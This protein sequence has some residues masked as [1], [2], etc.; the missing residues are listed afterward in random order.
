MQLGQAGHLCRPVIHFRIDIGSVL[1]VP[2]RREALIPD[3]LEIGRL[4]SRL[5]TT[6]QEVTSELKVQLNQLRI[7]T[8]RKF[9]HTHIG[10]ACSCRGCSQIK[11]DPIEITPVGPDMSFAHRTVPLGAQ[12]FHTL[13][14]TT[15]RIGRDIVIT[16]KIGGNIDIYQS[17]IGILHGQ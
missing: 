9:L 15:L 4:S 11:T 1:A 3:T 8:L 5:R 16:D 2:R 14:Q 6:Y 12:I 10:S 7:I 13:F 17:F